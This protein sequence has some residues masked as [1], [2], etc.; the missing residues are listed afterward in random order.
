MWMLLFMQPCEVLI[1]CVYIGHRY[2]S[3]VSP[4]TSPRQFLSLSQ[5]RRTAMMSPS[6]PGT[7]VFDRSTLT[8]LNP[9][10]SSNP[11]HWRSVR[12]L[13]PKVIMLRS[14]KDEMAGAS[15]FGSTWSTITIREWLALSAGTVLARI[16]WQVESGQSWKMWEKK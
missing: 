3:C 2:R 12:S 16:W 6:D 9:T 7:P 10:P 11:R 14:S 1:Y 8:T 13:P 4:P 15:M 5:A